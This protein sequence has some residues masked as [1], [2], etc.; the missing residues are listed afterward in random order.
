MKF[1]KIEWQTANAKQIKGYEPH[2]NITDCD[3]LNEAYEYDDENDAICLYLNHL[4]N[5][6]TPIDNYIDDFK[7]DNNEFTTYLDGQPVY[8]LYNFRGIPV[9][10]ENYN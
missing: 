9:N 10:D 1:K 8:Q 3:L 6:F 5:T 4:A 7:I 2:S